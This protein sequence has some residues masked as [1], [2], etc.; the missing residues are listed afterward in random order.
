MS[1]DYFFLGGVG[2]TGFNHHRTFLPAKKKRGC[3][4][5]PLEDDGMY[6]LLQI[7]N[8]PEYLVQKDG[9]QLVVFDESLPQ[10]CVCVRNST[11]NS[12]K[13]FRIMLI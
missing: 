6:T 13:E 9:V 8:H 10:D 12:K 11:N 5:P 2:L 3:F 7:E 1:A 4:K